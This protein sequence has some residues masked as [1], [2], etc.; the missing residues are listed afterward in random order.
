MKEVDITITTKNQVTIPANL[1]REL[2]L[3]RTRKLR[4]KR[5]GDSIVLTPLPSLENSLKSIW[6]RTKNKPAKPLSEDE[7]NQS[8][9][10]IAVNRQR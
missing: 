6:D 8:I 5:R 9:R 4:V 3:K 7:I 2:H 1:V 10:S